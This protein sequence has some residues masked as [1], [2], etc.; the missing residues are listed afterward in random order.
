[1]DVESHLTVYLHK[2]S[3]TFILSSFTLKMLH[4]R[5][6]SKFMFVNTLKASCY[7]VLK[8]DGKQEK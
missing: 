6:D 2:C 1:M 8:K 7:K 4:H 5:S 3:L